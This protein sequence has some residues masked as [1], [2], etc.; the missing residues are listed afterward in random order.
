[1]GTLQ[2][3]VEASLVAAGH[4]PD[5]AAFRPHL[6]LARVRGAVSPHE[7]G[8]LRDLLASLRFDDARPFAVE[9]VHLMRSELLPGGARH[10]TLAEARLG[11]QPTPSRPRG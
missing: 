6:T 10:T 5:T 9:S 1:M 3:V 11:E 7:A 4:A 2:D 8:R